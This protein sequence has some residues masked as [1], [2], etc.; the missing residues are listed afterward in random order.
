MKKVNLMS[1]LSAVFAVALMLVLASCGIAGL[2][3]TT[4]DLYESAA[5]KGLT[6]PAAQNILVSFDPNGGTVEQV[7]KTVM[8][9][10][11]YGE[12]PLPSRVGF[13]FGGWWTEAD[14]KGTLITASTKVAAKA[15]HTLYA[16]WNLAPEKIVGTAVTG[17]TCIFFEFY[18]N[19]PKKIAR[20]LVPSSPAGYVQDGKL[21]YT[22]IIYDL[23][24]L[25][26]MYEYGFMGGTTDVKD[27]VY[28]SFQG[29]YSPSD[30]FVGQIWKI[31][32]GAVSSGYF[33][34]TPIFPGMRITNY[35][36]AA[37]Y[38]FETP[39]PQTL[40]FNATANLD[41]NE[42]V[43][44]WCESGIGWGLGIHGA[45]G[46][47]LNRDQTISLNAAPLPAFE[48]ALDGPLTVTGEARF[49]NASKEFVSGY[50][51]LYYQGQVLPSTIM[52]VKEV[53]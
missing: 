51:N 10:P 52:A 28:Y 50:L 18:V 1:L 27:G 33:V 2:S 6:A 9:G 34:G 30:G 41:T 22:E 42:V 24:N 19:S 14:G 53:N 48:A 13:A 43:G 36:G 31:D 4:F 44:T 15:D 47:T 45:L 35:V 39:T 3:G 11:D 49:K 29:N 20:V 5:G 23:P 46:G 7:S 16:A 37:T 21:T 26:V 17:E 38:L 25:N 40:L 8:Y 12:L 32:N